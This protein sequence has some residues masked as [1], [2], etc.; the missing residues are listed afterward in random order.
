MDLKDVVSKQ[1]KK[2]VH[3]V[4]VM[5]LVNYIKTNMFSFNYEGEL[6]VT[7]GGVSKTFIAK[8]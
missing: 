7:I 5:H 6:V 8:E 1:S 3:N 2:N 4:C